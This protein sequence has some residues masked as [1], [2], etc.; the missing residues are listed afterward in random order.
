M[1]K[2][3]GSIDR[4]VRLVLA[5]VFGVLYYMGI[6]SGTLGLV[7]VVLAGVFALT[8]VLSFCPLYAIVGLNTC[9]VKKA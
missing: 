4:V 5:A 8:S 7:L 3:V 6:I 2:N 1:K 9:D